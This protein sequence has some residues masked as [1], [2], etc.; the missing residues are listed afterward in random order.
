MWSRLDIPGNSTEFG[1]IL[2]GLLKRCEGE[3]AYG[4]RFRCEI[5]TGGVNA[6]L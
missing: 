4:G 6:W 2:Y 1:G 5:A 3:K